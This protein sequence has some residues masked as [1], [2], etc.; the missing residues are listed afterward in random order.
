M[1]FL[2]G[3]DNDL[4]SQ[5]WWF[6]DYESHGTE[7]LASQ[8]LQI[9]S[10]GMIIN[11]DT[12]KSMKIEGVLGNGS[13]HNESAQSEV[14]P[15]YRAPQIVPCC[16]SGWKNMEQVG[17][18]LR[19]RKRWKHQFK[20]GEHQVKCGALQCDKTFYWTSHL[21]IMI[22][23]MVVIIIMSMR[24][25][26]EDACEPYFL[27]RRLFWCNANATSMRFCLFPSK[28]RNLNHCR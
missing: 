25:P 13:K 15:V 5:W 3:H 9:K 19:T 1:L 6:E 11:E 10:N 4:T 16:H 26:S 2:H 12:R 8:K 20:M 28:K 17:R 22:M 14:Q 7:L 27:P 23:V 18:T 21:M 24:R